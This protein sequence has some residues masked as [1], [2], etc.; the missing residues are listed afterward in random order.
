MSFGERL[1]LTRCDRRMSVTTLADYSGLNRS[2]I[3]NL[4]N[5]TTELPDGTTLICLCENL[6]V[7]ADYLLGLKPGEQK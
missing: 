7:S 1:R 5:G 3:H 2:T 4:E 6:N